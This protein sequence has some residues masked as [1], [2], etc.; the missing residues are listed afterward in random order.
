MASK[1]NYSNW[2]LSSDRANAARRMMQQAG[3]R[4][5][6]VSQV[7]GFADQRLRNTKDP[8]DP[9]NRRIS[10]IVQYLTQPNRRRTKRSAAKE[11]KHRRRKPSQRRES[12]SPKSVNEK[13]GKK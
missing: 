10:I 7:R 9:S 13:S 12:G 6:Q 2:E 4:P 8:F 3:L 1:R 5:D 11:A